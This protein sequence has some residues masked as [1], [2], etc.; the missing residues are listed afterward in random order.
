MI[1]KYDATWVGGGYPMPQT[2]ALKKDMPTLASDHIK[3]VRTAFRFCVAYVQ[4]DSS[5]RVL[6]ADGKWMPLFDFH[7]HGFGRVLGPQDSSC[8]DN[9]A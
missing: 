2:W 4:M 1:T 3:A 6:M 5:N 9:S 7:L 8:A